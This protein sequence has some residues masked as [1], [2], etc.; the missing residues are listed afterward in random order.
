MELLNLFVAASMPVLKVLL[1]TALG[2]FLALDTID[3]LGEDA[4]NSMNRAS[5][6]T[7][8]SIFSNFLLVSILTDFIVVL[9]HRLYS[10]FSAQH[11][12]VATWQTLLHMKA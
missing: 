7:Q 9:V 3:L 11:L 1:L 4:R 10:M 2:S 6:S 5:L 8:N 12:S